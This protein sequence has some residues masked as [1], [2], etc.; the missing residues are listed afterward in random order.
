MVKNLG[1]ISSYSHGFNLAISMETKKEF[2]REENRICVVWCIRFRQQHLLVSMWLVSYAAYSQHRA[3]LKSPSNMAAVEWVR[4]RHRPGTT[5]KHTLKL[6]MGEL[7]PKTLPPSLSLHT[8]SLLLSSYT[9]TAVF[10]HFIFSPHWPLNNINKLKV[11]A[12][13][14]VWIS[15]WV[16]D[17]SL[18]SYRLSAV[19]STLHS[20]FLCWVHC[21]WYA[22][23]T[24][25]MN[26]SL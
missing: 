2:S 26:A 3:S 22:F 12:A 16:L 18:M 21:T 11:S 6:Q 7:G 8:H 25:S 13:L 9:S 24:M 5:H 20:W 15:K 19:L 23:P 1:C 14:S 17:K 10:S 4:E